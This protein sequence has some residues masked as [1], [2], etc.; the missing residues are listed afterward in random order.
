[1]KKFFKS[2]IFIYCLTSLLL[3]TTIGLPKYTRSCLMPNM[4]DASAFFISPSSCCD[5]DGHKYYHKRAEEHKK[6]KPILP[7]CSFSSDFLKVD[8]ESTFE[9]SLELDNSIVG[10]LDISQ[11]FVLHLP[12]FENLSQAVPEF[13]G[14]SPPLS[15]RNIC[16]L[17]QNFLL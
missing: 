17:Y 13:S 15:G 8:F 16:I 6:P 7:C 1:M 3:I 11:A 12:T 10:D 9:A 2:S 5:V 14:S 4:E